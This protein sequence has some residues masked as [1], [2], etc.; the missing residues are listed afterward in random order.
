MRIAAVDRMMPPKPD[1]CAACV[2]IEQMPARRTTGLLLALLIGFAALL[3][4]PF[5][6][7]ATAALAAQDLQGAASIRPMAIAQIIAGLAFW[8]IL[9]GLPI[10]RLLDT[11]TRSRSIEISA[12]QVSIED[13]V[14]GRTKIWSGALADFLG[15]SP[16][17][18]ASLSGVRHEL[19][20]V[21]PELH[22][23]VLVA[24]A[25][26][27]MQSEVDQV[28]TALGLRELAPQTFRQRPEKKSI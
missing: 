25:P 12:G 17:L 3:L 9:L 24:M 4:S 26:R 2:R 8:L 7:V 19:I 10:Y 20:L 28:T 16:Y 23:S 22:R 1:F 14:F 6:L 27:L 18:R 21:H 11:L 5:Y 13:R 15:V